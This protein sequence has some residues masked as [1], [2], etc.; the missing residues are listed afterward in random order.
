M[1]LGTLEIVINVTESGI[2]LYILVCNY[3]TQ[4]TWGYL[5]F[6]LILVLLSTV[7]FQSFLKGLLTKN[8]E[9]RLSWPDLLHH[10]FVADGVLGDCSWKLPWK[11][12]ILLSDCNA[13]MI[14]QQCCR[15]QTCSTLWLSVPAQMSSLWNRSKWQKGPLQDLERAD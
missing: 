3:I 12:G 6:V 10:P 4:H 14:C 11:P 13:V 9:K 2:R 5:F 1:S 8:P 7:F 15:T